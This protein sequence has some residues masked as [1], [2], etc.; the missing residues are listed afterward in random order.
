MVQAL[1]SALTRQLVIFPEEGRQLQRLE[2]M[3]EQEFRGIGHGA[4][5]AIK[6]M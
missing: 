4:S 5:P 3:G 6:H 1:G 2:V